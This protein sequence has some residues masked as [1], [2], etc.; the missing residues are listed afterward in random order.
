V[1]V[2]RT[3]LVS[4]LVLA[5]LLCSLTPVPAQAAA[6]VVS[7]VQACS[8]TEDSTVITWITDTNATSNVEYGT[9]SGVYT[10][11]APT[12]ADTT[13]DHT[14]H[15]V[16]L[17]GLVNGTTYY[18]R[19]KSSDGTDETTSAEY[20]FTTKAL[21]ISGVTASSITLTCAT[22]TWNTSAVA[23]SNVEYGTSASYGNSAPT[24]ADTT[25]D[26]TA[27]VV[28]LS[29]LTPG[30]T[31]HYRVKSADASGNEESSGDFTFTTLSDTT[32]PVISSVS[33]SATTIATTSTAT[34]TWDTDE[35][36]TSQVE[37]GT[38]STTHGNYD[39]TSVADTT[40]LSSHSYA[41]GGLLPDTRYYYRVISQDAYENEAVSAE[42]WFTTAADITQPVISDITASGV[43]STTA[44]ITWTTNEAADS[45]VEYGTTTSYGSSSPADPNL[46]TSHNVFLAGL[47]PNALYHYRVKSADASG[48]MTISPDQTFTT[49]SDTTAP[50][51]SG[52]TV[53]TITTT[54]ATISWSTDEPATS[55]VEYKPST[56]SE[57]SVTE[58][59]ALVFDHSISLSGLESS[60]I[61]QYR[62]KSAD[63]SGNLATSADLTFNTTDIA[64]PSAPANLARTTPT[65]DNTPTFTWDAATDTCTGVAS[66]QVSIDSGSFTDIGD[67]TTFT[68]ADDDA[69][70]D[71]SHTIEVRAVDNAGNEGEGATLDF[72]IDTTPPPAPTNLARTS[73][74]D[75]TTPTFTWDA[76]TDAV[77][78]TA[79][80]QVRLDSGD[81]ASIGNNTTFT[82]EDADALSYGDHVFEVRAVDSAGNVGEAASLAFSVAKGTSWAMILGIVLGVLAAVAIASLFIISKRSGMPPGQL[83]AVARAN[84]A[85]RGANLV[86]RTR[87]AGRPDTD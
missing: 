20:S 22:I 44:L 24:P 29:G 73:P 67:V 78:G 30:T 50:V 10:E 81:F 26:S 1:N 48:N 11:T 31:Y 39:T 4:S 21:T 2:V 32:A 77:S 19:V 53:S 71:G 63:G 59:S 27:H 66:Y 84:V 42:Y 83:L 70:G 18:Y 87:A 17:S 86:G 5:L 69:L 56:G 8:V 16:I 62:V 57:T 85:R 45:Q 15:A 64:G 80:Y 54:T 23:T 74:T 52:I 55:R 34:I 60:T 25:A 75:D 72:T 7:N 43:T 79:A 41:L 40:L 46:V 51:I 58:D 65:R 35:P 13:A 36:A 33:P 14:S 6:P 61:Y 37:Y 12:P 82:V 76:A 3:A 28:V 49:L 38:T 47:A 9:T 68:V